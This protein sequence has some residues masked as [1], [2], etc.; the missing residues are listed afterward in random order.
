MVEDAPVSDARSEVLRRIRDALRDVPGGERPEDV[1]VPRDYRHAGSSSRADVIELLADRLRE[2]GASVWRAGT[3]SLQSELTRACTELRLQRVAVPAGLPTDWRP[4]A[5]EVV[6]DHDLDARAL[7]KID[8]ALTG[9]AAAIAE[10]GTL[11]L[12]GRQ[13]S[14]RRALTLVPDNHICVVAAEQVVE[15]VPEALARV[16]GSVRDERRP[17][18]LVSG[19]SASSDIELARVEGVHGPRNLLVLIVE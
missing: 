1:P 12:D 9:C 4:A 2:Y 11:V 5:V 3:D 7:D 13:T 19:P 15:S 10:T 14:G 8:A 16:A 6:E 17:V 18:T